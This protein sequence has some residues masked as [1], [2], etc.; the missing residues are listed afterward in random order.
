M[1][2]TNL[3]IA[4]ILEGTARLLEL[5]EADA[6]RVQDYRAAADVVRR[7]ETPLLDMY[8]QESEPGLHRFQGLKG[9][10]TTVIRQMLE[11]QRSA[12]Q[13][14]LEAEMSPAKLFS[15]IPGIGQKLGARIQEELRI[16]SLEQLEVAAENGDLA[17][18]K[19][20]GAKR[21]Q[22]VKTSLARTS[23]RN[24]GPPC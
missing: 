13:D 15:R 17:R 6:A 8:R 22:S 10:L 3:E 18:V 9:G 12:V 24:R 5:E 1:E 2:M 7:L 16:N 20:I 21:I 14:L 23:G 11:M 4:A 19:G